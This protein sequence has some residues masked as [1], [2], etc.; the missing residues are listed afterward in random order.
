MRT[1]VAIATLVTLLLAVMMATSADAA[2]N[3]RAAN[4]VLRSAKIAD[5][6][7]AN[8]SVTKVGDVDSLIIGTDLDIVYQFAGRHERNNKFYPK[9]AFAAGEDIRLVIFV[10][11]DSARD[12]RAAFMWFGAGQFHI[13]PERSPWDILWDFSLPGPGIYFLHMGWYRGCPDWPGAWS[14]IS[15]VMDANDDSVLD[16]GIFHPT[17]YAFVIQ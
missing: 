4:R 16:L 6:G 14:F 15:L 5:A 17:P 7:E 12:V 10:E 13:F 2:V 9:K 1:R 8:V 11:T 3:S